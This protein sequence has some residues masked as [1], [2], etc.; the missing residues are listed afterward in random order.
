[1]AEAQI[2]F[3]EKYPTDI[4]HLEI[5]VGS[6]VEAMGGE[7]S[8]PDNRPPVVRNNPIDSLD[9]IGS[10]TIP[11]PYN[12]GKLPEMLRTTELVKQELGNDVFLIGEADAGPF[13][14]AA[15]ILGIRAYDDQACK[16]GSHRVNKKIVIYYVRSSNPAS[17]RASGE[18][19]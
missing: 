18:R 16:R 9:K 5:G 14:L 6:L 11:D 12:D 10:L 13:S 8:W 1:M 3:Q 17:S 19:R 15:Q 4:M 2:A 7:V